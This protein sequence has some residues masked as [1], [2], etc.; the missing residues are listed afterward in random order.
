VNSGVGQRR[1]VG[2]IVSVN[3]TDRGAGAES[4][5]WN[6]F[7]GFQRRGV[8]SWLVVGDKKTPD[9]Y[10]LPFFS[11][12][13]IDYGKYGEPEF[14][15]ALR[16]QRERDFAAGIESFDFPYT[17]YLPTITG[18]APDVT[19]CHNLHGGYFDLRELGPLS[20]RGPVFLVLHDNWAF[21]GHCAYPLACARWQT[22]CGRCP[23]LTLPPAI[24]ADASDS[25]WL[26]KANIYN[27][28][29]LYVTAPT[30]W[31]MQRAKASML[32]PAMLESRVIPCPVDRQ[33]FRAGARLEARQDLGLPADGHVLV[34]AAFKNKT[35][36]YK[37]Y[38]TIESALQRLAALRP[39]DDI[40]FVALGEESPELRMGTLRFRFLPF[41]AP[42]IVAKYLRAADVYIHAAREENF[43]LITAEAAAC[44]TPVV[45][46]A[47]G[48]LQEVI[49][50]ELTGLL[51]PAQDADAMAHSIDRLLSEPE[52]RRRLGA[53]AA[54]YARV[55]WDQEHVLDLFQDWFEEVLNA[56]SFR[57]KEAM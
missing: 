4:V 22:G 29:R 3:A 34:Y 40:L 50:H 19:L 44:G 25:N 8:E 11:S 9:P 7:K 35:N 17:K 43:G 10:V 53:Q 48:G 28:C 49:L 36:P 15:R 38:A 26:Q 41:Q 54:E 51:V 1:T 5:A 23:D 16:L 56:P 14:Q 20:R 21:T 24:Q 37:D 27:N 12:P 55:H 39:Q 2:K 57:Q 31:M 6:L 52:L 47:V 32:A 33:R 46:T 18:S 42:A 45:A 13:Y 30:R